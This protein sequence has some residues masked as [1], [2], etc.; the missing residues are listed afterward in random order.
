MRWIVAGLVIFAGGAGAGEVRVAVAANFLST[1]QMLQPHYEKKSGDRLSISA[2]ASGSLYAQ[3]V[4]GAPFDLLL[5]ADG[6][7]P[8]LLEQ[9]G[10]VERGSRFI[11]AR[12]RL[13]LWSRQA[14]GIDRQRLRQYHGR[15]ALA[16]PR[17]APYGRAARQ[18]IDALDLGEQLSL[19]QGES[20][21]QVFQ[22]V[23]SGNVPYGF[24]ALAQVLNSRNRWN[25][26][27]YW[28]VPQQLY[29]PLDQ[30]AALLSRAPNR[31]GALRFLRFIK[32]GEAREI[33]RA[34]GYDLP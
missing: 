9:A 2:G 33:I 6:H 28:L 14:G 26:D 21:A 23:A 10:R 13:V 32:S 7:Y 3:I 20:V 16:N 18:V 34:N 1:L 15:L 11:Y 17:T 8:T 24:V 22:F 30:E 5:A 19:I 29:T 31:R 12:G 27:D 4:Q 25:R